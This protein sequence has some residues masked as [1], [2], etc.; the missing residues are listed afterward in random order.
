MSVSV[1]IAT[2]NG[3]EFIGRQLKSILLQLGEEDEV[4][5]SDDNSTDNTWQIIE[6]IGDSRVRIILNKGRKGPIS[7]F[8]N[9]LKFA[10]RD[11]IFLSD[12]DDEWLSNK[13]GDSV[14]ILKEFDLVLSDCRIVNKD[15]YVVHES[16]F[17]IRNSQPGFWHNVYRNSYNGCCM[18]FRREVLDYVLPLP[19]SIHMHDWWIGLLVEVKGKVCFYPKPL[20]NYTRHG[21]NLSPTSETGYGLSDRILNRITLLINISIRLLS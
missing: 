5:I 2:Y 13:V 6:G 20:I 11:I 19:H 1:C 16:F 9:A 3:A 7:N 17:H 15:G 10:T 18:A 21:G 14:N 4:I 8:E 12:Q